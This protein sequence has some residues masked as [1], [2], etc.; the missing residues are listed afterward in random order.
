MNLAHLTDETELEF[1]IHSGY[2]SG[3]HVRDSK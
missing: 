1:S 2:T 3:F